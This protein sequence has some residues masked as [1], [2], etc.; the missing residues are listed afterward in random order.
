[1][2][3]TTWHLPTSGN[4]FPG[5][6]R[7]EPGRLSASRGRA[8]VHGSTGCGQRLLQSSREL[9]RREARPGVEI[10]VSRLIHD[11]QETVSLR[12]LSNNGYAASLEPRK[13]KLRCPIK[14]ERFVPTEIR[15]DLRAKL[16]FQLCRTGRFVNQVAACMARTA[17][18]TVAARVAGERSITPVASHYRG[19]SPSALS[20]TR[21]WPV[22]VHRP[23]HCASPL[24]RRTR[25]DGLAGRRARIAVKI[26]TMADTAH[27]ARTRTHL[28]G[29]PTLP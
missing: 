28:R 14:K 6:S 5:L 1:M 9:E 12:R 2:T 7:C 4:H 24:Q 13:G 18:G 3:A 19:V 8:S 29:L 11:A 25:R 23:T 15:T 27:R 16:I 10:V 22:A 21:P 26:R 17:N 20:W